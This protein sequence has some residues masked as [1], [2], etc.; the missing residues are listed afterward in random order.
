MV[1]VLIRARLRLD[2]DRS[3]YEALNAEMYELVQ[4]MPGFVGASGYASPEGDEI[5]VVRFESHEALRA[6]REHPAHVVTQ[7]R[8]RAEFY[9]SLQIEVCEVIRSYRFEA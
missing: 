7:Q 2:A 6:W 8:G 1:V 4:R 9:A 5:G 3:A